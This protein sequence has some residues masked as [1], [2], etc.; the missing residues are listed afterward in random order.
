MGAAIAQTRGK[1]NF[2]AASPLALTGLRN[3]VA[4][5]CRHSPERIG[6]MLIHFDDSTTDRRA[7]WPVDQVPGDGRIGL[8]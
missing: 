7:P 4:Y 5:V 6:A 1:V 3:V 8:R 2:A